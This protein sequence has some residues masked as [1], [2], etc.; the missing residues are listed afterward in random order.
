MGGRAALFRRPRGQGRNGPAGWAAFRRIQTS[1]S[2]LSGRGRP[3][4]VSGREFS[5]RVVVKIGSS[6]LAS[7]GGGLAA[8]R[9]RNWAGQIARLRRAGHE[10]I[11]VSSGAIR[12]GMQALR[13]K[14]RPSSR[15]E[16]QAC[17]TIGQPLLMRAY[18]DA[19]APHRL[20]AAQILLTSWDLDSRHIYENTRA[21]LQTLLRQKRAVPVFNENDA[22]SF[23]E[24]ALLNAFG[25]N[26]RLSA[27]VAILAKA[28]RL[29]ILTD[30]PG[31]MSRPDGGG[32][33]IRRVRKIDDKVLACAGG[34]GSAGSVGG[35]RSKLEAARIALARGV[36][37]LI[38][39][40]RRSGVLLE[41]VKASVP[42]TW[43]AR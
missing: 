43:I 8:L 34:A 13:M 22:L 17:A 18:A 16:L 30:A 42:G 9:L 3:A 21:T 1:P 20:L 14:K 24:I 35:M 38:A 26:D 15:P 19:L 27:H 37:V 29:V 41:S 11:L 23:E 40:G 39:D 10:V 31:L 36:P 32:Q 28:D 2:D 12:A 4:P 33:L 5:M 6:L 25:D 7:P